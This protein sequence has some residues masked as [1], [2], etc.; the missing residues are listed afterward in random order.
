MRGNRIAVI[1]TGITGLTAAFQLKKKGL[2]L[3]VFEKNSEPGGAIKSVRSG[4]W[5]AEY[6]PNTLLLK[7]R[8][9]A[10]FLQGV[11]L[12]KEMEEANPEASKRF[13]VRYGRLNPLPSSIRSAINTPLFSL[14]GKARILKEPFIR[15]TEQSDETVAG[16]VERRL[17]REM[18]DYA[19]NPFVAGIF[20]SNPEELSLRHAFPVM[21]EMEQEYGSLIAAALFGSAK[22][23]RMGRIPGKLI[24]FRSGLQQLPV[25][26]AEELDEIHY[27]TRIDKIEKRGEGWIVKSAGAAYGPFR[28][29]ILNVPFYQQKELLGSLKG[30]SDSFFERV[31]YPPLSVVHL[32]YTKEQIAHPLDGFGFLIPEVEKRQIL[33]ALFSSTLFQKR[34]P[35]GHHLLTLFAGGGRQPE[36]ATRSTE[37]LVALMEE[38]LSELIGLKGSYQFMDHVYWPHAIPTYRVGYDAILREYDRMERDHPGLVI[39][40]NYRY[41]ISLP[42]CIK[43]GLK[44][45]EKVGNFK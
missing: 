38:E 24:S 36:I 42:D 7:D 18:L 22:R 1:G 41:G 27:N 33:G 28:N 39:A 31:F 32:G 35:E 5:L 12:E 34:A 21:Y 2:E 6:G 20:A 37:E 15:K 29:V 17:G 44:L 30:V 40:G 45:A 4:K 8:A 11:G 10:E 9:V 13:I 19:I 3:T 26:I 43:N 16:F 23:K 25:R 14:G